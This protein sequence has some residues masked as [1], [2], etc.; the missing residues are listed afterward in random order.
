MV[1]QASSTLETITKKVRRLTASPSESSLKLTDIE[2]YINT[3]ISQDFPYA[4]KIDQ[5]KTV[6]TILTSPNIDTYGLNVNQYQ[7]LRK[8]VYFEGIEGTF[9]KDRGQFFAVYP[10]YST[11]TV[12]A[13]GDGTETSFSFTLAGP[14]LRGNVVIG[15][16]D[17]SGSSIRVED[18]P[19][20]GTNEGILRQV[21][22]ESTTGDLTF[23]DIGTIDYVSGS[24]ALTFLTVPGTGENINAWT[25]QY[26]ASRPYS[27]LF[28]NNEITIRPVPDKVYK[29]E[30][31]A[32][33]T[34]TQFMSVNEVPTVNQWW[35]YI[36][37][38]AAIKILQDRQDISGLENHMPEFL[39]QE[40]LV[41]ER[42]ANDEIGQRNA[43]IFSSST[44]N[45]GYGSYWYAGDF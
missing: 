2:E 18:N 15:T 38:G 37:Y 45:Q 21:S 39:R 1:Q 5:L 6:Y 16:I 27:L 31:E 26:T 41:L 24:V 11:L 9:Y 10:R 17:S 22:S 34:P 32:F 44:P 13:S 30:I 43:T 35:Q 7:S 25:S 14:F 28:W 20:Y 23:T 3:F 40:A 42:Q 29:I 36:A 4:I 8:P 12:P 19:T 33:Q